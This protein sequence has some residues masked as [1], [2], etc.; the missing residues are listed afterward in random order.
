MGALRLLL[1]L[2]VACGHLTDSQVFGTEAAFAVRAFFVISGF[3]MSMVIHDRYAGRG[4]LDFYASRLLKLLPVYWVVFGIFV[5]AGLICQAYGHANFLTAHL[6]TWR[7]IDFAALP[8]PLLTYFSVTMLSLIGAD[9]LLF[10]AF[11]PASGALSLAPHW[12]SGSMLAI[13][14]TP[15]AQTWS[16]GT[17]LWFYLLAPFVVRRHLGLILALLLASIMARIAVETIDASGWWKRGVFPSELAL[18]L[19][20][21]LAYRVHMRL[22]KIG[23][24]T[25]MAAGLS[26]L[27]IAVLSRALTEWSGA[28]VT[29]SVVCYGAL[30]VAIPFLFRL[31][32][33]GDLDK[34]FGDLSYPAYIVQFLVGFA[35]LDIAGRPSFHLHVAYDL[36]IW[37]PLAL[38]AIMAAAAALH[39][40]VVRPVDR[41]RVR[42][43]AR[44]VPSKFAPSPS[45][46]AAIAH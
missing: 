34:F 19:A 8:W 32:Q 24:S 7:A 15:I 44:S 14:L 13:G 30:A 37:L 1:A 26:A 45:S 22:P 23:A 27:G 5:L 11:D 2:V 42:F 33:N 41:L 12:A 16:L 3:Y 28:S 17:E 29:A 31:T 35:L 25:C 6:N 39:Y 21:A 9:T 43:G 38:L 4:A 46:Q 18:F 40:A 36:A 20:G 10:V